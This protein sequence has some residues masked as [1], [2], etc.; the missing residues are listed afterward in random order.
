MKY[1]NMKSLTNFLYIFFIIAATSTNLSAW[2][3]YPISKSYNMNSYNLFK[4]ADSL[5]AK[6]RLSRNSQQNSKFDIKSLLQANNQTKKLR[7]KFNIINKH[8]TNTH[9]D[10]T[11]I[12]DTRI[13]NTTK[14]NKIKT[15]IQKKS[16]NFLKKKSTNSFNFVFKNYT[17]EIKDI[18]ANNLKKAGQ[19]SLYSFI[20]ALGYW[21][22]TGRSPMIPVKESWRLFKFAASLV[23][24]RV[25]DSNSTAFPG[26]SNAT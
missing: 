7:P 18:F 12:E 11:R 23:I 17:D 26:A 6:S 21:K 15:A 22:I 14:T 5:T 4:L 25:P 8:N 2:N 16:L 19:F 24:N 9:I 20:A 10:D 13:G 3:E 1:L